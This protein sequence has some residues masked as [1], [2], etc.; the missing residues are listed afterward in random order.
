MNLTKMHHQMHPVR[1]VAMSK[2]AETP[3]EKTETKLN[4]KKHPTI[5]VVFKILMK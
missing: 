5:L 2:L 4:K 1:K 3:S